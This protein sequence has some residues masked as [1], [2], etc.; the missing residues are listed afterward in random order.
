MHFSMQP[1]K[2]VRTIADLV[3]CCDENPS[4]V[5]GEGLSLSAAG[6]IFIG[7]FFCY[8]LLEMA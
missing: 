6:R 1:T 3:G 4:Y 2:L 5:F 8:Q 7:A